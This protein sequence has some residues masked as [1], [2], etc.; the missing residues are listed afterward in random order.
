VRTWDMASRTVYACATCQPLA[1]GAAQTLPDARRKAL[2][3]AGHAREFV[4]HCATE[5]LGTMTAAKM[6]VTQL[7]SALMVRRLLAST[8]SPRPPS[9]AARSYARPGCCILY[10]PH[11]TCNLCRQVAVSVQSSDQR[12]ARVLCCCVLP[13]LIASS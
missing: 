11:C 9:P 10:G 12:S 1:E 4:S 7:R 2:A 13:A 8:V 3:A 6:T 5:G